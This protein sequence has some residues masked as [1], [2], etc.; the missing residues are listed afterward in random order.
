MLAAPPDD[1]QRHRRNH[2]SICWPEEL[3]LDS[4]GLAHGFVM[5]RLDTATHRPV[6]LFWNPEDR[7]L[8]FP[9]F[10]W[11]YL[12]VAA[13]N[14]ASV[15]DL[16]HRKGHVIG[17][18]NEENFLVNDRALATLVD[19]DSM[20][21]RDPNTGAIHRCGVSREA[22]IAP[23][24][25]GLTL[26]ALDRGPE[27]DNWALAVLLFQMLME[28]QHPTDGTGYPEERGAR[29]REGIMPMLGQPGFAPPKYAMPFS[30]LP[31]ALQQLFE[32]A[33][34]DGHATPSGRPTAREWRDQLQLASGVLLQCPQVDLHWYSGHLAACPW[35]EQR[36]TLGLDRFAVTLPYGAQTAL[37]QVPGAPTPASFQTAAGPA[38]ATST[39][40][41]FGWVAGIAALVIFVII[42]AIAASSNRTGDGQSVSR[43][44]GSESA[45]AAPGGWA[46]APSHPTPD[47]A[48][49]A[50]P[51]SPPASDTQ[52]PPAAVQPPPTPTQPP[53]VIPPAQTLPGTTVSGAG[54]SAQL[55][56]GWTLVNKSDQN[57]WFI[58]CDGSRTRTLP[59]G[60]GWCD[61]GATI[62]VETGNPTLTLEQISRVVT[63]QITEA[64]AGAV[65]VQDAVSLT[66]SNGPAL[67]TGIEHPTPYAYVEASRIVVARG[68]GRV[69][70]ARFDAPKSELSRYGQLFFQLFD[71]I[72]FQ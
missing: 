16:I 39:S 12:C 61:V 23:E 50:P 36:E 43:S 46:T 32:R 6:A 54:F 29:I 59:N 63:A 65:N 48:P 34:R 4:G 53:P 24:A 19:C 69:V 47:T 41:M 10:T 45:S 17:D 22:Y 7:A 21:V 64:E 60:Q 31:P 5:P 9:G 2:V 37:P 67:V 35:C 13:A 14:I 52:F 70:W 15:V 33:F 49:A 62:R 30:I 51:P 38:A 11:R 3:S 68:P 66:T 72:R 71:S 26:S 40:S 1:P 18:I 25:F 28:G 56:A 20:Q 27:A 58:A 8:Y 55:P 44:G 57:D 42:V